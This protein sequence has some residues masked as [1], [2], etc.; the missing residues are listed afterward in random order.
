MKYFEVFYPYYAMIKA[1]NE[2]RAREYYN[3]IVVN[4]EN[5]ET[6]VNEITRDMALIKYAKSTGEDKTP[7]NSGQIYK[8]FCQNE[9][10]IL[11]IDDSLI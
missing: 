4:E 6:D 5:A 8:Q 10:T 7:I 11:L 1:E 2:E 3:K 9:T